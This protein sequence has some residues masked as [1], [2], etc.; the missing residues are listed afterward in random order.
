MNID[1][2]WDVFFENADHNTR[3]SKVG[4]WA[5]KHEG[6]F[7]EAWLEYTENILKPTDTNAVNLWTMDNERQANF[8]N[9]L[10]GR[11]KYGFTAW[12]DNAFSDFLANY[13][14]EIECYEDI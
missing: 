5:D 6:N 8:I 14:P 9:W 11:T 3:L 13:G 2:L 10:V 4:E 1:T 7:D 12:L